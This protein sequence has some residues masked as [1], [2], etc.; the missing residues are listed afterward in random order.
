VGLFH[1]L[2]SIIGMVLI[3]IGLFFSFAM[4]VG[5]VRFPD[6]Y[7]RLH[8]GTKGL[9]IGAGFILLGSAVMGPSLQHAAKTVLIGIFLF[10]TNPISIHSLARANYRS[11]RARRRL[12]VDEYQEMKR[13][14]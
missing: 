8:A 14:V 3:G 13:N 4:S 12:V 5:M 2:R 10:I 11:H 1:T 6:A 9:T 7:S